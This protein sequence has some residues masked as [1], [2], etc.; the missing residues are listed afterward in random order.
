MCAL[1]QGQGAGEPHSL[2]LD[3]VSVPRVELTSPVMRRPAPHAARQ[4][5]A[6]AIAQDLRLESPMGCR[7]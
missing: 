1:K 3:R 7:V 5:G 6:T 4:Q 2:Q